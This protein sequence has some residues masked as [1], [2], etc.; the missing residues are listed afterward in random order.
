MLVYIGILFNVTAKVPVVE[1]GSPPF[2]QLE[3]LTPQYNKVVAALD[4][5]P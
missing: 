5:A 3:S 4:L 2:G 1:T